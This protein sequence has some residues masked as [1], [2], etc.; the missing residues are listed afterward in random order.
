MAVSVSISRMEAKLQS[1]NALLG[2]IFIFCN[3]V[4]A[5]LNILLN[6]LNT[7]DFN[8]NKYSKGKA[9]YHRLTTR[10]YLYLTR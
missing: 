2:S 9:K 3:A 5:M 4:S 8:F 7:G 1:A 6:L 10:A